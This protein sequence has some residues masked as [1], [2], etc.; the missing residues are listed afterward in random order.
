MPT[1]RFV[2]VC[3]Y[4]SGRNN[5]R[6][7]AKA[8]LCWTTGGADRVQL[9]VLSRGGRRVTQWER[10]DRLHNFRVQTVV[11]NHH[12]H[13]AAVFETRDRAEQYMNRW[14]AMQAEQRRPRNGHDPGDE[15]RA[16]R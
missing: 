9:T 12:P 10:L 7:G 16:P 13:R 14:L 5:V 4:R 6:A 2:V 15:D 3:N 8:H 11:D 1:D